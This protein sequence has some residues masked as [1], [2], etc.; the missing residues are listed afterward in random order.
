M[1][2]TAEEVLNGMPFA[3]A[4]TESGGWNTFH[5]I[6]QGTER[7]PYPTF[8]VMLTITQEDE[9]DVLAG[10]YTVSGLLKAKFNQD[11]RYELMDLDK[12]WISEEIEVIQAA[13]CEVPRNFY[14]LPALHGLY[15]SSISRT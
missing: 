12:Q 7:M 11:N 10:K 15:R 2:K 13:F 9:A 4:H 3:V 1:M 14:R 5:L 8:S 6:T